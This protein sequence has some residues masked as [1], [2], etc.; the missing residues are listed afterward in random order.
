MHTFGEICQHPMHFL[1]L[2]LHI[3]D[4]GSI[5]RQHDQLMSPYQ[6][7]NQRHEGEA[8]VEFD[9]F[10]GHHVE[11]FLGEILWTVDEVDGHEVLGAGLDFLLA[12]PAGGAFFI[13]V[14]L[15]V[16]TSGMFVYA[17]FELDV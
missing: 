6:P 11:Q 17:F 10:A 9:G 2:G 12:E 3:L 7:G 5:P 16:L 13:F 1:L 15:F 14:D 4:E 8:M